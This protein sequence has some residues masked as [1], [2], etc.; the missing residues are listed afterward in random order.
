MN[1]KITGVHLV[2]T[3]AIKDYVNDRLGSLSKYSKESGGMRI[4][5]ELCKTTAHHNNGDVFQ[6]EAHAHHM[7]EIINV[8]SVRDDLYAAIDE[9]KDMLAREFTEKKDKK[10]SIFKRTARRIKKLLKLQTD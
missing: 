6:A 8:K 7:G 9:L 10:L 5:V 4:D 3:D 1:I 2:I